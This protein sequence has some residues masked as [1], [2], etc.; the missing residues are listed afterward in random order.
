MKRLIFKT[1]ATS[2]IG[3]AVTLGALGVAPAHAV[4][5]A[6]SKAAV[7]AGWEYAGTY[8]DRL[9]CN[10]EANRLR[11]FYNLRGQCRG[12]YAGGEFRLYVWKA[13]S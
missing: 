10:I 1:F 2:G 4:E 5:S 13:G 6:A 3:V 7:A 12:P 9:E 8:S 11:D